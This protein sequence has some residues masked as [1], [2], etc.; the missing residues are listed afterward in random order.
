MDV[1]RLLRKLKAA[2]VFTV[3]ELAEWLSCSIP[4]ARRRLNDW[5][6]HTS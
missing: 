5:R 2:K 4:T 3:V 1:A 6:T